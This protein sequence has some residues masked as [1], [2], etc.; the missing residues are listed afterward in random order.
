MCKDGNAFAIRRKEMASQLK[1]A[2][3]RL[4]V[5]FIKL[6]QF[7]SLRSDL[8]PLELVQELSL[9]QDRVPPFSQEQARTIIEAELGLS[10]GSVFQYFEN[11]PLASASIGQVHK[12]ILKD[13][14]A[15]AIKI[16]RADL[17]NIISQDLAIMR[18]FINTMKTLHFKGDWLGWLAIV[19][20]FGK[21]LAREMDY[22]QEGQN[23][24]RLRRVL[25]SF[26]AIVIPRVFWR[27]TTKH[28]IT[29]ELCEGIKIDNVA[30][31]QNFDLKRLCRNLVEAY[32]EQIA[33]YGYFHA[34]PHAGNLAVGHRGELIIYD[35]GMMGF[36]TDL[37]RQGMINLVFSVIENRI[38]RFIDALGQIGIIR[39]RESHDREKIESMILPLWKHLRSSS[40]ED[41]DLSSIEKDMQQLSQHLQL[42]VNIVCLIRMVVSLEAIVR[43]LSPDFNFV[44]VATPY[45]KRLAF[46]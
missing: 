17:Q 16:Q 45:F 33:V 27:Y 26:P 3:A 2:F 19:D 1:E 4:G 36:L 21:G 14:Q 13:G 40:A 28:I 24:D 10:I 30:S 22:L 12:A 6:G 23:A 42:P 39:L 38:S 41:F 44:R 35:F 11:Q 7:L 15:V 37:Q 8:L 46:S 34:D 20:E 9:L 43:M 32:L 31:L 29:E 5:T 25:R 18:F